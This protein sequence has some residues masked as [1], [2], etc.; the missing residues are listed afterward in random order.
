[1]AIIKASVLKRDI[2][3]FYETSNVLPQM[4]FDP[5]QIHNAGFVVIVPENVNGGSNI[6]SIY[7]INNDPHISGEIIG[8]RFSYG[9]NDGGYSNTQIF[10][11]SGSLDQV[12]TEANASTGGAIATYTVVP[13]SPFS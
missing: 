8:S 13:F 10:I 4:S 6:E 1:M 12:V 9:K 11:V 3:K 7:D 2:N 5:A